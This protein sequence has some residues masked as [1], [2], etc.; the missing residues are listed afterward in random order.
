MC[1]HTMKIGDRYKRLRGKEIVCASGE[2]NKDGKVVW[3]IV[4]EVDEDV[5]REIRE[6][7]VGLFNKKQYH[8]F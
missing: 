1:Q 7:K 5:F 8:F 2:K 6:Y 4:D 3:K